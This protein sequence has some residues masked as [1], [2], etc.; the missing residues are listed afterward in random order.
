[1]P[2]LA[3]TDKP[4]L[5]AKAIAFLEGLFIRTKASTMGFNSERGFFLSLFQRASFN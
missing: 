5:I 1:M 2:I 4:A 3:A